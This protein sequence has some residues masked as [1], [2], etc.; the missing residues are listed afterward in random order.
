[1]SFLTRSPIQL[2]SLIA[3][4]SGP[5]RGGVASF[6]GT[7]RDHHEGRAVRGIF[8]NTTMMGNLSD[9]LNSFTDLRPNSSILNFRM[10]Q[11][12]ELRG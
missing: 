7:V 8:S 2:E 5:D 1:M 9:C 10:A 11:R 3:Q 4:V 12:Y 6:L